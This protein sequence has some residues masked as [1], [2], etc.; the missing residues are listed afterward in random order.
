MKTL[1]TY[2][3]IYVY[4]WRKML[5]KNEGYKGEYGDQLRMGNG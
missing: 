1:I 2:V 5:E 3:Y 4:I